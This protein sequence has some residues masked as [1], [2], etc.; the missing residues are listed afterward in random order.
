MQESSKSRKKS[1]LLQSKKLACSDK[2]VICRGIEVTEKGIADENME[3]EA[4]IITN[5]I[6]RDRLAA[7]QI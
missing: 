1:Y 4:V 7:A 3:L 5:F 2:L 6:N